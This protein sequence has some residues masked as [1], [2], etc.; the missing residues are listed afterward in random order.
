MHIHTHHGILRWLYWTESGA[1]QAISRARLDGNSR[2]TLFTMEVLHPTGITI[3]YLR[4]QLVWGD[5]GMGTI[6]Y[7]N[8]D[9][10]ERTTLVSD[11]HLR[12]FQIGIHAN[13]VIWTTEGETT[14]K[15]VDLSD[16]S[17][18]STLNLL[19]QDSDPLPLY[20]LT[21]VTER[22]RM[23]RGKMV[24]IEYMYLK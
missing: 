1:T 16:P 2:E 19:T 9:G 12:P 15:V 18:T 20:G 6:E 10:S 14:F 4:N 21:V 8:L 11:E 22:N 13:Y 5:S 7:S 23:S 24:T 17:H 3:D